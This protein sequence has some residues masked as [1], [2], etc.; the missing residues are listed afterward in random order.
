MTKKLL[1]I[2]IP[3]LLLTSTFVHWD[4]SS[5]RTLGLN[6]A[7]AS[8]NSLELF[9]TT[10]FTDQDLVSYWRMEGNSND[11]AD[12]NN[13][14]DTSI[15]YNNGNGKFGQGAGLSAGSTS[16]IVIGQPSNLKLTGNA[17]TIFAYAKANMLA[18]NRIG[19]IVWKLGGGHSYGYQLATSGT[20]YSPT[21]AWVFSLVGSGGG[22]DLAGGTGGDDQD[23]TYHQIIGTYDGTTMRL[24][25]DCVDVADST[26]SNHLDND[27]GTDFYIGSADNGSAYFNGALDEVAIFKDALTPTEISNH[28]NGL[29]AIPS[30]GLFMGD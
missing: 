1:K 2:L 29:D 19:R 16:H 5:P 22:T 30:N 7:F 17:I 8:D 20:V 6:V 23:N 21:D 9:K 27:S 3:V 14:T 10:L 15:T 12:G 24:Y 25:R 26:V 11:A 13:G 18:G 28:C 4:A